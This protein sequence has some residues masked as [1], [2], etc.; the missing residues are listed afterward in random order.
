MNC[1]CDAPA[2]R[3]EVEWVHQSQFDLLTG[4]KRLMRVG[5]R[6]QGLAPI[7]EIDVI[8]IAEVLDA[9]HAAD[10]AASVPRLDLQVFSAD[11]NGLRP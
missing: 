1:R 4:G 2:R 10:D 9:V 3:I 8:L 6:N 11:S 5:K 7:F